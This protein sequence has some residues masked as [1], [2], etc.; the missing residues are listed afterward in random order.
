MKTPPEHRSAKIPSPRTSSS[1]DPISKAPSAEQP[2]LV[3]R[4]SGLSKTYRV[5]RS[6]WWWL[7]FRNAGT[8]E[9]HALRDIDLEIRAGECVGL[10]GPNGAGKTTLF[11]LLLGGIIPT[12]GRI[13][14]KGRCTLLDLGSGLNP[15]LSGRANLCAIG[16]ATGMTQREIDEKLGAMIEFAELGEA[17]DDPVKTYSSGM[18]MRLVFSLHAQAAPALLIV[19]EAFAVGDARF[20]LKCTRRLR[21]L[22]AAGTA[23]LLASHDSNAIRELCDRGVLLHEGAVRYAG[24]PIATVEAYHA[25]LGINDRDPAPDP[26]REVSGPPSSVQE[27]L[28]T[29][30][31][32]RGPSFHD[33]AA[34][35]LGVRVYRN[36]LPAT[37]LF[38]SGDECQVEWL[39]HA[40]RRSEV[41]T[42]GIH[43]HSEL[44]TYVFGTS[45]VHLG[46]PISVATPSFLVLQISVRLAIAP[47]R[48][49]L[50]VGIAE[51]DIDGHSTTG[52]ML[53]RF[54]SAFEFEVQ[55]FGLPAGSPVPF[56]GIAHLEA[57]AQPP[58]VIE[59]EG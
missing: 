46:Q 24:D 54:L 53:D 27:F 37:S 8:R 35:I 21:E 39:V 41:L 20:V 50:S 22:T 3:A 26:E 7:P 43:I 25:L 19:D 36:G 59:A 14:V 49:V 40:R 13:E 47:G 10:M 28:D 18:R 38:E 6:H 29:A 57:Q 42:S 51:P 34:T 9:I 1:L 32:P 45:Y 30:Y 4:T 11:R 31:K 48:Y 58:I 2:Y 15:E 5:Y 56:L 17:I 52:R 12:S 44:G 33:G 16:L 55:D 23:I